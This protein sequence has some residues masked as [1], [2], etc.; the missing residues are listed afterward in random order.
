[1]IRPFTFGIATVL[2]VS[3]APAGCRRRDASERDEA[4]VPSPPTADDVAATK[5]DAS[6]V[7]IAN[8]GKLVGAMSGFAWVAG[9]EGT[10]FR[11]PNPCDEKSCFKGTDSALCAQGTILALR[12]THPGALDSSCDWDSNWG[13]KIG[14]DVGR[15]GEP[16]GAVAPDAISIDYTGAPVAVRLTAHRAGDP[17]SKD[18]CVDRYTSA[19]MVT[20]ARF[21]VHCWTGQG[22][23]LPDFASVD[24]VGLQIPSAD[25]PI[26]FDYCVSAIWTQLKPSR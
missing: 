23:A 13:A 18:Y 10:L 8:H 16:W 1:V 17:A 20:A 9:G 11:T 6:R 5:G 2:L 25:H 26:A 14:L 3:C 15:P 24:K 19:T 12:C 21:T 22:D 4:S 7:F